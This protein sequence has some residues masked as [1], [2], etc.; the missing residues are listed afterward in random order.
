MLVSLIEYRILLTLIAEKVLYRA[1]SFRLQTA[2][3]NQATE[4]R[5]IENEELAYVESNIV[6]FIVTVVFFIFFVIIFY[7]VMERY[8]IS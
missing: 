7:N 5:R 3:R 6:S 8:C 2:F 1:F 4:L